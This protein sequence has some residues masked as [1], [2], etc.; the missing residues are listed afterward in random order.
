MARGMCECRHGAVRKVRGSG[1]YSCGDKE[2]CVCVG[3]CVIY[4]HWFESVAALRPA[5][6]SV[7]LARPRGVCET[8][9]PLVAL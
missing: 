2:R 1:V 9:C 7:M 6:V 8:R 3:R 5:C 4:L